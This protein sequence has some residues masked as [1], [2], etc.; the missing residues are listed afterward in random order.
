MI[1]KLTVGVAALAVLIA[2][3]SPLFAAE[4]PGSWDGLVKV[5]AKRLD[6]VYLLPG[7]DFRVYTKILPDPTEVA[8]RK[9]WQRDT[10]Q[11][12]ATGRVSDSD[13]RRI[14]ENARSGFE[15]IFQEAYQKAGYEVVTT[16][17]PDVLKIATAVV[18]LD[19]AAPE[20]MSPGRSKTWSREAG[21]ATLVVEARDSVT[22]ALLG[23][24]VDAQST[25][26]F[27][28]YLRNSVTNA[29]EFNS[30]FK[31]WA[32]IAADGL[33]ELKTLSPIDA[34]GQAV[35]R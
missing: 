24:A 32:K 31:R 8:F 16:P 29:G 3:P 14:L 7:A 2:V 13:A 33:G 5:D 11:E 18:N 1:R 4:P 26:D 35:R 27:G 17:G 6:L 23:R 15:K 30:L 25:G 10:N 19:V 22:G 12:I 9:N 21:S 28:P 34:N 20:V